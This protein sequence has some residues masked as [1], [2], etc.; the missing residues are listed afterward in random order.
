[1]KGDGLDRLFRDDDTLTGGDGSAPTA[2]SRTS[3]IGAPLSFVSDV[4]RL[5]EGRIALVAALCIYR[6]TVVCK[7]RTVTLPGDDLAKLGVDR[8]HKKR[9]L[10]TLQSAGLIKVKNA[11]GRTAKITLLWQ[12][13]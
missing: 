7:S 8:S 4:C 9:A 6:R 5:T 12:K 10:A 11:V 13:G 1:V 3:Y 2:L